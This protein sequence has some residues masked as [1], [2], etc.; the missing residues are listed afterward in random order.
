MKVEPEEVNLNQNNSE[1]RPMR[2]RNIMEEE[3]EDQYCDLIAEEASS[4]HS[5]QHNKFGFVA[6]QMQIQNSE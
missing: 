1:I 2:H 5:D 6:A 4:N 3:K